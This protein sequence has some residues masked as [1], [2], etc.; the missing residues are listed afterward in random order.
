MFKDISIDELL[1]LDRKKFTLVD[2]RSPSEY[3]E[4]TIPGSINIP[5]FNDEERAEVGTLYK[6]VNPEIAKERGLEI[7]AAKLPEFIKTFRQTEGEKVV[8]CWRGGMRSKSAATMLDLM[9]IK[10]FRLQGGVRMYRQWVLERLDN[11][12][13]SGEVLILNGGTGTGKTTILN[14]LKEKGMPVLDLEGMAGHRGSV[15]GHIG[16]HPNTQKKFDSLLV[17]E[18]QSL[19]SSPF[20][21]FEAESKRIGKV[22]VPEYLLRKKEQG[23]HII[24]KM[25]ME[26]R[27]KHILE[28]YKLQEHHEEF[29]AAFERIKKHIHT[30]IAAE[31]Q[32]YIEAHDY[33]NALPMLLE[34]YY[35]PKYQHSAKQYPEDQRIVLEVNDIDE[36]VEAVMSILPEVSKTVHQRL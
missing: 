22:M 24:L 9:G 32:E 13:L 11:L 27:V 31:I 36:A 14:R 21:L 6:Q 8:F 33:Q 12:D 2:V 19:Q 3:E 17:Q 1:G 25:P 35:D 30:P 23:T 15:F 28:E 7:F 34:Y 10:A 18:V 20:V 26:Q 29:L 5:V 4:M 16:T